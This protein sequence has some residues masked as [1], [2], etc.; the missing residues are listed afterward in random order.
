MSKNTIALAALT[1]VGIL[2]AERARAQ[3]YTRRSF[4][5]AP[6]RVELTGEPSRPQF[7]RVDVSR[8]GDHPI[9]FPPHVYFG[10]TRDL[11]LG[12]TH[13]E[14]LCITGC[15]GRRY[16]DAGFGLLYNLVRTPTFELDL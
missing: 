16:R 11:T 6:G 14:G 13:R 7:I 10:V 15:G 8:D 1:L 4:L 9:F 2:G 12:I 3:E 5:V